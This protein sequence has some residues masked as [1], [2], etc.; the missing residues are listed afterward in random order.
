[1]DLLAMC[2]LSYGVQLSTNVTACGHY[3][4]VDLIAMCH[5]SD[6]GRLSTNVTARGH[7]ISGP[8]RDVSSE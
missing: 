4:V 5:L 3:T 6:D 7:L 2:H 8:A 1:M